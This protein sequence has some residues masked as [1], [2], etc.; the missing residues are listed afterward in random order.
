MIS[1][2]YRVVYGSYIG[3]ADTLEEAEKL[4]KKYKVYS[5]NNEPISSVIKTYDDYRNELRKKK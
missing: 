5:D 3:Y 4:E 2:I 1:T